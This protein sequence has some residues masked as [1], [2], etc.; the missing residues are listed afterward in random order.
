[1]LDDCGGHWKVLD[2]LTPSKV[3]PDY[4]VKPQVN[5]A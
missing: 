5:A 4:I 3:E 1:M 2:G